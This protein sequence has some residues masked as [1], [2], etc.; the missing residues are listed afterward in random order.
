VQ[1]MLPGG[2]LFLQ[3]NSSELYRVHNLI[4]NP[5]AAASKGQSLP[6]LVCVKQI[7]GSC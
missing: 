6:E 3:F 4:N 2:F 7:I 5:Q 1:A